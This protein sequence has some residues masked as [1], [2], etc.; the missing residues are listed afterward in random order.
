MSSIP[1]PGVALDN[2]Q[3]APD[4]A[5]PGDLGPEIGRFGDG[6]RDEYPPF[7]LDCPVR[8]L[9]ISSDIG[10]S[11]KCFYLNYN[12][13]IVG[14]EPREHGKLNL[15]A[16]FGPEIGWLEAHWAQYSKPVRE[17]VGG[18]WEI[19]VESKIIGFDQAKAA[20]ALVVECVRRG[21]FDPFGR[22][23]GRGAH[24]S[25]QGGLVLH[26][27][28]KLMVPVVSVHGKFLR[29]HWTDAGLHERFVYTAAEPIARPHHEDADGAAA[30]RLLLLLRTWNWKRPLLDPR[31]V[32]GAIGAGMVGGALPWRPHIWIT[33]GSGTGKSTLNG[34]NG[35]VHRIFGEGVY[36]SGNTTAAAIRQTLRNS[37]VP[38]MLD[39]LEAKTNNSAVDAVIEMA[40]ISS[41]GDNA[42]R[43]GQD[44]NAAQFT[45]ESCFWASSILIPPMEP[46]DRTR[47]VICELDPLASGEKGAEMAK[48][49][50]RDFGPAPAFHK[51][52][53]A[54]MGRKLLRRMV[55]GWT[56]LAPT[57]AKYHAALAAA[58]H[59][60]RACDQIGT[61]LACADVLIEDFDT[62]DLLPDDEHI[63]FWV[64][65]CRPDRLA[66]V[67]DNAPE[68]ELCLHHVVTSLQQ[69]RG[70]DEREPI[71]N[72][73]GQA[74]NL[75]ET[76][77]LVEESFAKAD[78]ANERLQNIGLKLVNAV[79]RPAETDLQGETVKAERWGTTAFH[80][81][82]PGFL[83]VAKDHQGLRKV[84]EGTKWN[85]GVWYQALQ[86][87]PEAEAVA[88]VKFGKASMRAVLVPLCAVL[89]ETEVPTASKAETLAAWKIEQKKGAGA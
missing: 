7:P 17:Q 1:D 76:P 54:D 71:G 45:L 33:G 41:S 73:I 24:T 2:P 62:A 88:A 69:A 10:G 26:C 80:R 31:F 21:I 46:Q 18:K 57:K 40:R 28:D 3:E 49:I 4:F 14:K 84:F 42:G 30:R 74:V 50:D 15:A 58:G 16:L 43:G 87:V 5:Q 20:E 25:Q 32:L 66:E 85:G 44:H 34:K 22:V 53:F 60:A 83:A 13:Q 51:L 36:R 77:L 12:G 52:N 81:D 70:G 23:R 9:G 35:V 56:L 55:D 67:A 82:A 65:H 59:T 39:E 63:A 11:Q 8:P 79:Y 68:H 86:R 37:T 27:G 78:K 89:D 38:V 6:G 29:W 61:L 64:G 72:W 75:Q 48:A 47:F 19:V